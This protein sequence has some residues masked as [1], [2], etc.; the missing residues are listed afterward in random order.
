MYLAQV[1]VAVEMSGRVAIAY[2]MDP[3]SFLYISGSQ[4]L[5]VA[6]V[7]HTHRDSSS[8]WIR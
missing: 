4:L 8:D 5:D 1:D 6:L 2:M 3:S 7:L